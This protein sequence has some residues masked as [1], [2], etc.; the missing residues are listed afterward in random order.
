M[1]EE[2]DAV[3][4]NIQLNTD[5]EDRGYHRRN[6]G[7]VIQRPDIVDDICKGLLLQAR[8]DRIVHGYETEKGKPATLIVFG[9]RFHGI[10]ESRRFRQAITP[11]YFKTE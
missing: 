7:D 1:G 8:V 11:F 6:D 5:A 4:F 9:F 3:S 10:D 2:Q